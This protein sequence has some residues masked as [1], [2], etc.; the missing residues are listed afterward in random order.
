MCTKTVFHRATSVGECDIAFSGCVRGPQSIPPESIRFINRLSDL[1][2]TLARV[3]NKRA[4][5]AE[6]L[7]MPNPRKAP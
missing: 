7:W 1:L 6:T 5:V 3:A 4:G 2:F